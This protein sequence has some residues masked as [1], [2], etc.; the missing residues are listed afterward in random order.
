[1]IAR[2]EPW[3]SMRK[4]LLLVLLLAGLAQAGSNIEFFATRVDSNL[5]VVRATGD[6]LILYD[7]YYLSANEAVYDRNT[8]VLELYGN[9]VAMQGAEYFAMGDY[10]KVNVAKRSQLFSPFF[11]LDR[12][13]K[14]WM[15]SL[16][17]GAT[18]KEYTIESGMVSGCDPND[19]FWVLYFSSADFD[20]ESRWMNVYNAYLKL[21]GIP[22]FY[23]PYFGYSLDNRRRSGLLV[24][25]FGISSTEGFYYEQPLY[26]ALQPSWDLELRPQIRTNRGK[27]VYGRFRFVDSNV[28]KGAFHAGYFR[29]KSAYAEQYQLA[30]M[31]HYGFDFDYTNTEVLQRWLGLDLLGQSGLYADISWMNDIDYIN[32]A[33]NDV[34]NYAT[35]NQV[36]SRVNL[37]YNEE[38]VYY[39]MNLRYYLDL[40]KQSN[41]DTLQN[42][43]ILRYHRYI[44]SFLDEHL[45][46]TFNART[47]NLYRE[48]G[49]N[50]VLG[51]V[52]LPVTLQT[53]LFDDYLQLGYSAQL[54]GKYITFSGTPTPDAA[55]SEGFD[56]GLYGRLYHV[57]SAGT[58]VTKAYQ[59]YGHT[60]G[61]DVTYTKAGADY[62]SGYYDNVT[63]T[64][65]GV[66]AGLNPECD[67]YTINAIEEAMDVKFSQYVVDDSGNPILFHRITQRFTFE[68]A[69]DNL[70]ELENEVDWQI[71]PEVSLYSDVF[72]NYK[73]QLFSKLLNSVRYNDGVFDA[74]ITD[75][76]EDVLSEDGINYVN[77]LTLDAGYR[78]NKHYRYFGRLAYDLETRVKK[79]SEIGFNYTKRC[80]EFGMRYVEN[81]RPILTTNEASSVLDKYVYFTIRLTPIGGT[82]VNYKLSE[83]LEGS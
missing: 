79:L 76:Y 15:S 75:L 43:P 13:T 65:G 26:L 9:I 45:Y 20:T 54:N 67:F 10:A 59:E 63:D 52:D 83:A 33:S 42:L 4:L 78:Y 34:V 47:N 44:D 37:F 7:D 50:A 73:R 69:Q 21:Y 77:Y 23:F 28:S 61:L 68:T 2:H 36:L 11:M 41:A 30:N 12:S 3:S 53:A 48:Q 49:V 57:L 70:S 60:M 6:V 19:P 74:G 72:Y 29:E 81:N 27:G 38:D 16:R 25:S 82:E 40:T 24:P 17:S 31:E 32:L 22:V 1:M 80:W 5:T 71:L 55:A 39:G 35:S 14:V 62:A 56:T 8:S 64:C 46:Y 18:E 58:Q 51:E 66:D